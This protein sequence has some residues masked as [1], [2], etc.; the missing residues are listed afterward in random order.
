MLTLNYFFAAGGVGFLI[1]LVLKFWGEDGKFTT[2]FASAATLRYVLL[3]VLLTAA[4][5][6]PMIPDVVTKEAL[7]GA[8]AIGMAAG[9][10]I[11]NGQ[12]IASK[13]KA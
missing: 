13:G 3:S 11:A 9:S 7:G 4:T 8:L 10:L 6:L 12:R 5:L 2:N 1:H